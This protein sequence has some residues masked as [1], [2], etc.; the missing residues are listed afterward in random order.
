VNAIA[1]ALG[2]LDGLGQAKR[3]WKVN[4]SED[5]NMAD[6]FSNAQQI[7]KPAVTSKYSARLR[8]QEPQER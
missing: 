1:A 6:Q 8:R 4:H 2:H 5:N 3:G 7:R